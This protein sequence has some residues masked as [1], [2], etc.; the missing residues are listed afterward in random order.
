MSPSGPISSYFGAILGTDLGHFS[1]THVCP[2]SRVGGAN[3]AGPSLNQNGTGN[4]A[5]I[6]PR[7]LISS[8]L[9]TISD[10]F[11]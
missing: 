4:V 8:T 1:D 6:E 3:V 2:T 7:G 5:K 11:T 9:S 10:I